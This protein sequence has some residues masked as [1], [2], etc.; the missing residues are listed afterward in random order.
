MIHFKEYIKT[1]R[2]KGHQAFT[3]TQALSDLGIS[4]NALNCGMYKLKKSGDIIS[5]ARNLYVI[6]PPEYQ[7]LGGLP[8]DELIPMLMRHWGLHYYVGLL[9][10]ALYHGASH[11]KPQLFQVVT[12]KQL[13]SLT[14]G[15]VKITFIYKHSLTHSPTQKFTVKTGYLDIATPELTVMDLLLYPQH[16]GGL[17]H[18][19]T[20]LSELIETVIPEKMM[21]L[22]TSSGEKAW[23]QRLGY[24]LEH[25][26]PMETKNRDKLVALIQDYL[27]GQPKS[28]IALAPEL[29]TKSMP[30][31]YRWM[32]IENTNIESDL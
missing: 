1:V 28:L 26:E 10:A 9:S 5:P 21:E 14:F 16:A 29:P 27:V 32:I 6:V 22:I 20:V 24:I 2:A 13:K 3:T 30:R 19:A 17:N 15:K 12:G 31:N 18:I 23:I 4:R 8:A 25:I 7:N 11:Q